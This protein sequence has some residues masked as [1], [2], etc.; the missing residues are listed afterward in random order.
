MKGAELVQN[1]KTF[2]K[3]GNIRSPAVLFFIG[4]DLLAL[5]AVLLTDLANAL[6]FVGIST[7]M[8]LLC[9]LIVDITR[10]MQAPIIE[11]RGAGWELAFGLLILAVWTFVPLPTLDFGDGWRLGL[12]LRKSLLIVVLP[13]IFLKLRKY[14]LASMG[15]TTAN[16]KKNLA[17]GLIT[18]AAM[19]IPSA[20]Y[21]GTAGLLLHGEITLAQAAI[22]FPIYFAHNLF[23]SGFSEEFFFRAFMQTRLSKMLKSQIGGLLIAALLFGFVHLDDIMHWYPG[24]TAVEAFCRAFFVQTSTGLVFGVLWQR[25]R[26]L[27]PGVFTHTALNSLNNFASIIPQLGL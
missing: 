11:V 2:I 13:F 7:G 21:G 22:A 15:L 27:I 3:K 4:I 8:L 19:A 16:W 5:A 17:V 20:F 10:K 6:V 18:F 26:S 24:T 23:L 25:T 1:L 14:P 9:W 12:I